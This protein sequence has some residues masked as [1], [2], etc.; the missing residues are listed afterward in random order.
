MAQ[1]I[2]IPDILIKTVKMTNINGFEDGLSKLNIIAHLFTN[3]V[4]SQIEMLNYM[5]V[6]CGVA[7]ESRESSPDDAHELTKLPDVPIND[8]ESLETFRNFF[9]TEHEYRNYYKFQKHILKLLRQIEMVY[10]AQYDI[11]NLDQLIAETNSKIHYLD[12]HLEELST[13][14]SEYVLTYNILLYMRDILN[15]IRI[16]IDEDR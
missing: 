16:D 15:T 9:L 2:Y 6:R 4:N 7:I 13:R 10:Y 12:D 8:Y 5:K 3:N 1:Y 11:E 14:Q